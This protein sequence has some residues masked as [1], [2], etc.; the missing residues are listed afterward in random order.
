MSGESLLH[1]YR[2]AGNTAYL[3]LLKDIA[4]NITQF[5]STPE[6]PMC[7]SYV[8]HNKPAHRQKILTREFSKAVLALSVRNRFFRKLLLPAYSALYNPIGRINERVNLSDW[9]GTNNVGEVPAGSCWCEV[10]A[11]LTYLELPAVYINPTEIFALR[12]TILNAN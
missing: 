4:H 11:M 2:A 1:L 3:E 8:W 5:V 6:N 9:G 7:T 10:S 12:L